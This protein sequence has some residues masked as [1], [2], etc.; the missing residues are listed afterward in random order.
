MSDRAARIPILMYHSISEGD[1]PTYTA[2]DIFVAQMAAIKTH[3]WTVVSLNDVRK[4]HA[5]EIDL[6]EKSLAITFDDGFT[7]FADNAHSV[8]EACGFPSTMFVPTGRVG[9]VE[10]WYGISGP[11]RAVMSWQTLQ[12]L[13]KTLVDIAPHSRTHVNLTELFA[14]ELL[15]EIAGSK[16]DLEDKLA[17]SVQHFAPPYGAS[18]A[19]VLKMIARHFE[20]SVGVGFGRAYTTSN[21]L[22]LPR[23]EMCYYQKPSVWNDFLQGKGGPYL[24]ARQALRRIGKMVR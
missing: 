3:D 1:G 24:L 15:D 5:G 18:N 2:P 10:D 17:R 20:L 8:L 19:A 4:W 13:D 6:P 21:L 11:Q 14:P 12:D 23:L 16:A 9:G 22:D 7:D